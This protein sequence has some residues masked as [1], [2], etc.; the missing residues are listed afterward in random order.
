MPCLAAQSVRERSSVNDTQRGRHD[1]TPTQLPPLPSRT[2]LAVTR[3]GTNAIQKTT[4]KA[5]RGIDEKGVDVGETNIVAETCRELCLLELFAL[6]AC[7]RLLASFVRRICE[8]ICFSVCQSI[9]RSID[10]ST[11][12]VSLFFFLPP[13]TKGDDCCHRLQPLFVGERNDEIVETHTETCF[14]RA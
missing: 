5:F 13:C 4:D 7:F 14:D 3:D 8:T 2:V 9:D 12:Q 1:W 10:Q 6:F 11:K